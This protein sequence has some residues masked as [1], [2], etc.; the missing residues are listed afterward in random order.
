MTEKENKSLKLSKAYDELKRKRLTK[1]Q[2]QDI[3]NQF[4][5]RCAYCGDKI[6]IKQM[7]VDHI[8]PLRIGGKDDLENMICAC[9]SCNKYKHTLSVEDFRV[10]I[11]EI[12]K[13]LMR[14]VATF[15]M[16]ERYGL[17]EIKDKDIKF[18]FEE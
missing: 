3:Y 16:A 2:R 11:S 17:I 13:R 6:T 9:R 10:H 15:R 14:D 1:E 12:T 18:L 8:D 4:G 5:G 7:Q